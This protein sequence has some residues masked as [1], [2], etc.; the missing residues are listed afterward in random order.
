[1]RAY[2]VSELEGGT[3]EWCENKAGNRTRCEHIWSATWNINEV[4]V[5]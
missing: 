4:K 2:M 5:S 3:L 1:M